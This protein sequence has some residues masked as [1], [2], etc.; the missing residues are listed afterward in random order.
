[1]ATAQDA[2]DGSKTG[3]GRRRGAIVLVVLATLTA[4]LAIFA[5]WINRQVF[6]TD[7]WT[8]TSTELLEQP[9]IRDQVAARLDRHAVRERRR[10]RGAPRGVP[11]ARA[12]A[13]RARGQRAAR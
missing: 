10:Q 4:F 7:N 9:V 11:A 5:I 8:K 6:N 2:A 3:R 12:T 1:M 13:R